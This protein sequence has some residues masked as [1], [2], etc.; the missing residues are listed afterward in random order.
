VGPGTLNPCRPSNT[1]PSPQALAAVEAHASAHGPLSLG[2]EALRLWLGLPPA[3]SSAPE[4]DAARAAAPA[5]NLPEAQGY[6]LGRLAASHAA[7]ARIFS[8]L[9]DR[10]PNFRP[11]ALLD[12]GAGPG[13]A[14]WAAQE[15]GGRGAGAAGTGGSR[16]AEASSLGPG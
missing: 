15:V 16:G 6:A 3:L 12:Y 10:L 4:E 11:R 2:D 13:T 8:E 14:I 5:Y 9:A 1:P 7:L